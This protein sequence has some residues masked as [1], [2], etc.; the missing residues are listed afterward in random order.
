MKEFY[1]NR[2]VLITGG[3]EGFGFSLAKKLS[4]Y[5]CK[6]IIVARN[7]TNLK[8]AKQSLEEGIADIEIICCDLVKREEVELCAQKVILDHGGVDILIN[9]A[10]KS[11][12]REFVNVSWSDID[13]IYQLNLYSPIYLTKLLLPSML[14]KKESYVVNSLSINAFMPL[15][16]F[17]IYGSSKSALAAFGEALYIEQRANGLNVVN[18]Y[19]PFMRTGMVHEDISKSGLLDKF[20]I[21]KVTDDVSKVTLKGIYKGRKNIT[22][23]YGFIYIMRPLLHRMYHYVF[24]NIFS[25]YSTDSLDK[26]NSSWFSKQ[27]RKLT[28][29]RTPF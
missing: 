1:E 29:G 24:F 23:G 28:N 17:S 14:E 15:A 11:I 18:L 2:T 20:R 6:I 8:L 10:A 26:K 25:A 16:R 13:N 19:L 12:R 7:E 21:M 27:L 9:N 5:P 3:S 4:V 22:Y